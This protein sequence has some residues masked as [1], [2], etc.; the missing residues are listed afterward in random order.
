MYEEQSSRWGEEASMTGPV[1]TVWAVKSILDLWGSS[2]PAYQ[3][4][5]KFMFYL[6]SR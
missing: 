4:F 2:E 3:W 6:W 1:L 5:Y